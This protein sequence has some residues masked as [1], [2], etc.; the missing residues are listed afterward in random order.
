MFCSKHVSEP[1]HVAQP[2]FIIPNHSRGLILNSGS[3]EICVY[4]FGYDHGYD[5]GY[6]LDSEF[7]FLYVKT[8][9]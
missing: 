2:D 7:Y 3:K 6:D 4:A 9:R 5:H 8:W 1:I